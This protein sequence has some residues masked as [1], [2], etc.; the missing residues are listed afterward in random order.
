MP[1][2][3]LSLPRVIGHRG[4]AEAAPENTL[5]S[6]REAKRQG[7]G[8]VEFDAKLSA[9]DRA[10]LLHDD[11]LDRTSNGKGPARALTYD[12]LRQLDAGSWKAGA[13][14]GEKMPLLADALKFFAQEDLQFNLELKPCP[15]R[16]RDTANIILDEVKHL[17]PAAKPKPLISSFVLECLEIARDRAPDYPRGLLF[18]EHPANWLDLARNLKVATVNIWDRD[19]LPEWI[20]EIKAEGYGLLVYTV[21]DAARARQLIDWGVDGVFTDAPARILAAVAQ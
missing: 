16:A 15:G 12:E 13:F 19:A 10:F 5:A 6:F 3:S 14:A 1:I 7:A 4:A 20:T 9:D 18:E 21:N 8:W 17:W 2:P 11:N